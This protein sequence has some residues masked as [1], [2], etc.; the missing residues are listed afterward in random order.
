MSENLFLENGIIYKK[1]NNFKDAVL[2][3]E[4]Y[5][6]EEQLRLETKLSFAIIS[7]TASVVFQFVN[8]KIF[9]SVGIKKDDKLVLL[10]KIEDKLLDYVVLDQKI[11]FINFDFD[12]FYDILSK[13][14]H[15]NLSTELTYSEY[16]SLKMELMASNFEIYDLINEQIELLKVTP[17]DIVN[18]KVKA[19]LF[20]YQKIGLNWLSFMFRNNCGC[21]L[22]DEMGLGKTLQIISLITYIK[23][24]NPTAHFLV[25]CPIS[26]LENW[27]REFLKFSES[28]SIFIHHG[29]YRTGL[30][31]ELLK[32]DVVVTSYSNAQ[33]DLGMLNMIKWDLVILDEAQ[34]IKNPYANRSRSVKK[35]NRQNSIAVT[36]TP[37]ENHVEDL[38]SIVDFVFPNYFGTLSTFQKKYAD[39]LFS[40]KQIENL[41]S[42][43]MIRRKV[44]DVAKDLP[45]KIEIPQALV[46]KESEASLYEDERCSVFDIDSIKI[47]TIQSLRMFC[48]HP[49]VY[50]DNFDI[51]DPLE[52]SSKYQR[53]CE[54]IEEIVS[55]DEK[56]IIFTSYNKMNDLLVKD[57]SKR[58]GISVYSITG[59][60]NVSL[61]QKI[62]DCFT[63]EPH[64]SILVLNP[65][66]AGAGLNITA[67]NH[68][69]HYNLEW[70]PSVED[71]ASARAYRRGQTKTVFIHRLFYVG[72][73]EEVINERIERKR[74]LSEA[75]VI[76]NQGETDKNDLIRAISLSPLRRD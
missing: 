23:T 8:E 72:T 7:L 31:T 33:S 18:L 40:A 11:F 65:K 5:E 27:K 15:L 17:T 1:S 76:G 42:P 36:G 71:Q 70:N 73:I 19:K 35:L 45:E 57:L 21:I 55:L 58:F 6:K 12:Y 54:I 26:L 43:I 75:M 67:A 34:N 62:I 10:K 29:N 66:A 3:R 37:F 47:D 49:C 64:S 60:T 68:V 69:I 51:N 39:D 41:L 32:Y 74:E 2:A 44:N 20:D 16:L 25:I 61:R 28:V 38:W 48:T 56:A 63:N 22:A 53:L 52:C 4:L 50:S 30:Y 14:G 59:S 9:V 24:I 13:I 46:M